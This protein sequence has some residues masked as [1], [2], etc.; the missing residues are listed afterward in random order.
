MACVHLSDATSLTNVASSLASRA[1][2]TTG[3]FLSF[4][5]SMWLEKK[6]YRLLL[7]YSFR[8]SIF[9]ASLYTAVYGMQRYGF[10]VY[11]R[12]DTI[13]DRVAAA[14]DTLR[15]AVWGPLFNRVFSSQRFL[16]L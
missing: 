8:F 14:A 7:A 1:I 2:A 12:A 15:T 13:G 9:T 6:R 5:L 11:I 4:L 16:S 10:T 3:H